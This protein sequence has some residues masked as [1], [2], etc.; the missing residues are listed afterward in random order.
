M[1]RILTLAGMVLAAALGTM[2]LPSVASATPTCTAYNDGSP[3]SYPADGVNELICFSATS[4]DKATIAT[5]IRGLP[6]KSSGPNQAYDVLKNAQAP[7]YFFST[8]ADAVDYFTN[9]AP[10]SSNPGYANAMSTGRCGATYALSNGSGLVSAIWKTCEWPGASPTSGTNPDI[11]HTVRHEMGHA[12][13]I[14]MI[15]LIG[16]EISQTQGFSQSLSPLNFIDDGYDKLTPSNW[17]TMTPAQKTTYVCGIWSNI[18]PSPLEVSL[19]TALGPVC[20][21]TGGSA[22]INTNYQ[23]LTPE[24][25]AE[26]VAPYFIDPKEAFAEMFA[27]NAG[28][29]TPP[30][31]GFLQL[32]DRMYI[33]PRFQCAMLLVQRYMTTFSPP[34]AMDLSI[35]GCPAF[36][37]NQM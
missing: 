17:G 3:G 19:G 20:T 12:Y 34:T 30:S 21:G 31:P 18:A 8:R 23:G 35:R 13:E 11:A 24:Q 1:K 5:A 26:L 32:T 14:A 37:Q 27:V 4:G 7:I 22:T 28:V 16:Y 25:I 15:P 2:A 10:F 9:V 6:R 33:S 29:T 36:A